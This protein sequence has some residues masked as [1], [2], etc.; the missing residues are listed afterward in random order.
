MNGMEDTEK[1]EMF[2]FTLFDEC[3]GGIKNTADEKV[4]LCLYDQSVYLYSG[5]LVF[6]TNVKHGFVFVFLL[7]SLL[8]SG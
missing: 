7:L 5:K 4:F 8:F 2:I 3:F 6:Q 1:Q